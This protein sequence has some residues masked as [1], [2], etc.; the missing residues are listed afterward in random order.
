M[1]LGHG[2]PAG[3]VADFVLAACALGSG[4]G[5]LKGVEARAFPYTNLSNFDGLQTV[6]VSI[7]L[8]SYFH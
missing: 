1:F 6:L 4:C 8:I 2:R 5:V 3:E 7:S